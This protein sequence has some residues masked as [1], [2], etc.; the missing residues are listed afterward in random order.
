MLRPLQFI[1]LN[2]LSGMALALTTANAVLFT[3]NRAEQLQANTRQ[4]YLQQTAGLE[5]LYRD[6]VRALAELAV[7]NNDQQLLQMLAAQGIY[8]SVN[9]P[10]VPALAPAGVATPAAAAK[11]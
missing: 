5:G 10:P 9:A 3:H 8:V 7:K 11:R 1:L 2:A 4:Q 6:I